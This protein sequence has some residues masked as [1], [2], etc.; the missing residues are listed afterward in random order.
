MSAPSEWPKLKTVYVAGP[1]LLGPASASGPLG[2]RDLELLDAEV[3]SGMRSNGLPNH[4]TAQCRNSLPN[5][6]A[7]SPPT[8]LLWG[9]PAP[10]VRRTEWATAGG[11]GRDTSSIPTTNQ[12]RLAADSSASRPFRPKL[13]PPAPQLDRVRRR[14]AT[15]QF[16]PGQMSPQSGRRTVVRRSPH[17]TRPVPLVPTDRQRLAASP[18]AISD[19]TSPSLEEFFQSV[20]GRACENRSASEDR[21][22]AQHSGADR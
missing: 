19:D 14:N 6:V 3:A 8:P 18:T 10:A 17:L 20:A 11:R 16:S 5:P 13:W 12:C 22:K 4:R 15:R 9:G 1:S 2:V 21:G 7:P